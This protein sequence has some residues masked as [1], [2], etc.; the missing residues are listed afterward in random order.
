LVAPVKI[1]KEAYIGA[2]S[3]ITQDVSPGALALERARQ[4]EKKG[5]VLKRKK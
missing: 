2:G 4:I 3:T 5:W 1:G